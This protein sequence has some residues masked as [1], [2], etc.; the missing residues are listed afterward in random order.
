[1]PRSRL[2]LALLLAA[3]ALVLGTGQA[4]AADVPSGRTLIESGPSGRYIVDGDWRFRLGTSGPFRRVEVPYSWN[5]TDYSNAGFVG[6]VAE[7]RKDFELPSTAATNAWIVRFESVN[8]RATVFLNGKEIGRHEGAFL[9]FEFLLPRSA[10]KRTGVNRLLVRVDNRRTEDDLPP[11]G[12]SLSRGTPTGG[13]WNYGGLLREVYL[14]RVTSTD[15]ETVQVLPELPCRTC[16][17]TVVVR[18][19]VRNHDGLARPVQVTG[20]YGEQAFDAGAFTIGPGVTKT[21]VKRFP[22]ASPELWSPS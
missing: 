22:V 13:W 11:M 18:A 5:V 12:Y 3:V 6:R 19:T 10:L 4:V 1:M 8:Y 14:R 17:A 7:Y 20:T 15:F 2:A 16:D 9:P 21:F